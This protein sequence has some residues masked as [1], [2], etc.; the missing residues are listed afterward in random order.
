MIFLNNVPWDDVYDAEPVEG[1][2]DSSQQELD[3]DKF[4]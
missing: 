1:I 2:N 3:L 4:S